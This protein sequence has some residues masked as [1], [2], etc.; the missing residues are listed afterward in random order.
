MERNDGSVPQNTST[1][2]G[3]SN[4]QQWRNPSIQHQQKYKIRPVPSDFV[5]TKEEQQLLD[6]YDILRSYERTAA[7]IK[8]EAARAK[9]LARDAE[10]QQQ[11]QQQQLQNQQTISQQSTTNPR[12]T[13]KRQRKNMDKKNTSY[14]KDSDDDDDV[15]DDDVDDDDVDDDDDLDDV[16]DDDDNADEN[17]DDDNERTLHERREAKLAALREEIEEAKKVISSST[18]DTLREQH[19]TTAQDVDVDEPMLKKKRKDIIS[20]NYMDDNNMNDPNQPSSLLKNITIAVT[21]EHDFSQSLELTTSRGTTLFPNTTNIFHWKPPMDGSAMLPN[22]KA[23]ELVLNDF[24]ILRAQSGSGN[25][26]IAIKVCSC[27]FIFD[28]FLLLFISIF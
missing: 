14:G 1:T 10:F 28:L 23:L 18:D 15:D 17:D 11:Q 16:S 7:R 13:N 22:E 6:M 25:N 3:G 21:P 12:K 20:N 8:E 4:Y 24:D 5:P 26:T 9:L 27:L 2:T 19:L